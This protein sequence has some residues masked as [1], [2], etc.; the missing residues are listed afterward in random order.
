MMI[1]RP[2][3]R[4]VLASGLIMGCGGPQTGDAL[5]QQPTSM[6]SSPRANVCKVVETGRALPNE[7]RETSGLARSAR[8]PAMFWTHNDAGNAAQIF[9][10]GVDGRMIQRVSVTGAK[11]VDWEDIEAGRCGDGNCLY[12]GDIGDND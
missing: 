4:I 12:V 11:L 10:I 6:T 2:V 3:L 7:V 8:N 1:H 5:A 9:A